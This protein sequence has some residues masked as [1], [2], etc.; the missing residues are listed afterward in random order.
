VNCQEEPIA[1]FW[2]KCGRINS[3]GQAPDRDESHPFGKI[4]MLSPAIGS[5]EKTLE[6]K[7]R[8]P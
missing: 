6:E 7:E 5:E 2:S 4:S 3:L 8:D 1:P